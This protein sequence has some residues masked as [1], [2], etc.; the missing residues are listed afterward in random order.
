MTDYDLTA[1]EAEYHNAIRVLERLATSFAPAVASDGGSE[2]SPLPASVPP[3]AAPRPF[4][5]PDWARDTLRHLL[6]S[7]PDALVV[8]DASGQI[9]LCNR[10]TEI[11]FGYSRQELLG[12]QVERLVPDRYHRDHVRQ[13]EQYFQNPQVRPMGAGLNLFGRRKDGREIP[14]EISLSPL[15]TDHGLLI[16]GIIRDVTEQKKEQAK[17]RNLVEQIPAVTFTA[18]LDQ[19]ASRLYVSPQIERLLGFSQQEWLDDPILWFRQLHPDDRDRWNN[20]FAPTCLT[21]EAFQEIYRFIAR[22]GRVV[23]VQGSAHIVCDEQGQPQ[24]LQG[25]A[26][27]ITA[28]KE[29]TQEL[30]NRVEQRT[31]EL[32]QSLAALEEKTEELEQFAHVAAHDF[33]QPL[34]SLLNYPKKLAENYLDRL[35]SQGAEW[36]QRTLAGGERMKRLISDVGQYSKVLRRERV[37]EP[38]DLNTVF[39]NA[40]ANLQAAIQETEAGVSADPLPTVPAHQTDLILLL[41]NLIAN[42]IKFRA[43]ER[44]PTVRVSARHQGG[45]WLLWVQDNGIGMESKYLKRIF[46]LG[47]RLHSASKYPGTGFGLAICEKIVRI[48]GGRIW[49]ESEPEQGSTFYFTLPDREVAS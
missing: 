1:L 37:F 8:I 21:G 41:Q 3:P 10:Q 33:N 22:D 24:L 4:T 49:A 16:T 20:Q 14:I 48:H 11:T 18:P 5:E 29:A 26:F 27:D 47:E 40:C 46:E 13:R 2:R 32:A 34:R 36:L 23:W 39:E 43:P 44:P 31:R 28:I 17:F 38:V 12:Q 30:E 35:D 7:L 6:E 19:T 42:A 15:H 9:L 25:V 45:T